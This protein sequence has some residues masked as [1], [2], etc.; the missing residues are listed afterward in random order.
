MRTSKNHQMVDGTKPQ[1][2]PNAIVTSKSLVVIMTVGGL[3][4]KNGNDSSDPAK[5]R[6][7]MKVSWRAFLLTMLHSTSEAVIAKLTCLR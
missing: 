6:K 5:N 3:I 2:Q 1:A 7:N 4:L